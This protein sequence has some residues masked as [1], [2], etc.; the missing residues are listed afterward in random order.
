MPPRELFGIAVRVIGVLCLLFGA[1]RL[2]EWASYSLAYSSV[3]LSGVR[4]Q[5]IFFTLVGL[6]FLRGAGHLVRFAYTTDA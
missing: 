1:W 5:S 2:T 3:L 4:A 6:V